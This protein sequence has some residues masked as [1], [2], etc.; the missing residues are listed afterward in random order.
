MIFTKIPS[1]LIKYQQK[2]IMK[3][4]ELMNLS[5]QDTCEHNFLQ[6]FISRQTSATLLYSY[7]I[8]LKTRKQISFPFYLNDNSGT[9]LDVKWLHINLLLEIFS[10][11]ITWETVF[12]VHNIQTVFPIWVKNLE[13][14]LFTE[15][16]GALNRGKISTFFFV[17][18]FVS[19]VVCTFCTA[20]SV[21]Y[22]NIKMLSAG[23]VIHQLGCWLA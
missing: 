13:Y 1:K 7:Y 9:S 8:F 14:V 18:L 20:L 11:G 5:K 3:E 2:L 12:Y 23:D 21:R 22:S 6:L 17:F 15:S 10:T 19:Q 4:R 16:V